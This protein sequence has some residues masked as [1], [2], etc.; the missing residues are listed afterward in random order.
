MSEQK[1]AELME[2]AIQINNMLN[3]FSELLWSSINNTQLNVNQLLETESK[4]KLLLQSQDIGKTSICPIWNKCWELAEVVKWLIEII[5]LQKNNNQKALQSLTDE[6]HKAKEINKWLVQENK[7]LLVDQLTWLGNKHSFDKELN[8]ILKL[9]I[10][11]V[12]GIIDLDDFKEINKKYGYNGWDVLLKNLAKYISKWLWESISLY[13]LSGSHFIL[14]STLEINQVVT[15][16][17]EILK[18]FNETIITSQKNKDLNIKI[19]F[20]AWLSTIDNIEP[21]I[22]ADSIYP[23]LLEKTYPKLEYIKNNWKNRINYG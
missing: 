2:T 10:P 3:T 20:S 6:K 14:L 23:F 12:F 8:S 9:K 15:K 16:L 7:F 22:D 4:L 21:T 13:R 18:T 5:I 1:N 17:N 19:T 11:F